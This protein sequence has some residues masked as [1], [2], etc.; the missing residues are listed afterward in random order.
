MALS[1]SASCRT[2][3][4]VSLVPLPLQDVDGA[5]GLK[6][7]VDDHGAGLRNREQRIRLGAEHGSWNA[8]PGRG[9]HGGLQ[10]GVRCALSAAGRAIPGPTLYFDASPQKP[11]AAYILVTHDATSWETS[12]EESIMAAAPIVAAVVMVGLTPAV[13]SAIGIAMPTA[14]QLIPDI[15]AALTGCDITY[16][17]AAKFTESSGPLQGI[18]QS[19]TPTTAA[20]AANPGNLVAM[21]PLLTT[22][23]GEYNAYSAQVEANTGAPPPPNEALAVAQAGMLQLPEDED[24]LVYATIASDACDGDLCA[25]QSGH[26][27]A[28]LQTTNAYESK[29]FEYARYIQE[30]ERPEAAGCLDD[31]IAC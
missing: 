28:Q 26:R 17:D 6:A 16:T 5:T 29:Q 31:A 10:R 15:C 9:R 27:F 21:A 23:V 13:A 20:W 2:S 3:T 22:A 12:S 8:Y 14:L 24:D 7:R 30:A 11:R 25:Q 19:V 18:I 1:T 4:R